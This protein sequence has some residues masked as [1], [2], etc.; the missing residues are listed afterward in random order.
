MN[1]SRMKR[2]AIVGG[3][4]AG[5]SIAWGL[6]R[7]REVLLLDAGEPGA[8]ELPAGMVNP[9]MGRLARPIW[10]ME[11]VWD[12]FQHF[13]YR[14]GT[15]G[16]FSKSGLLRPVL[17]P[18]QE[19]RFQAIARRFPSMA[20]WCTAEEVQERFPDVV[21]PRGALWIREA[22][23]L[24]MG[25]WVHAMRMLLREEGHTVREHVEVTRWEETSDA[26]RLETAEGEV[27]EVDRLILAPGAGFVAFPEL[28]KLKLHR[29]KGQMVEIHMEEAPPPL[30]G[31]GYVLPLGQR[32]LLGS[33]YE[34]AF[35][36][37]EPSPEKT[38][39]IL[40]KV[41][42]MWPA[43]HTAKVKAV[44][45]GIRVTV[46]GTRLPMVGPLPGYR[47]VWI[48][49]GLGT[50]GIL[51]GMWIGSSISCWMEAGAPPHDVLLPRGTASLQNECSLDL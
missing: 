50:R 15:E 12:A 9:F 1:S 44:Y 30:G 47:Y 36:D 43:V 4:L 51:M 14:T 23:V 27:F 19:E 33:S 5:V 6:S 35:S 13:L 26:V 2:T 25:R 18:R 41:A 7:H 38:R 48:V 29:I 3:G 24:A 10:R 17:H 8:S 42:R 20:T 40:E 37:K 22:G 34:H 31:S 32:V 45:T 39:E 16:L 28:R 11:E 49:G 21:A 46:P